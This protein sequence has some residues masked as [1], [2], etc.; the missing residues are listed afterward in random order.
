MA[1]PSLFLRQRNTAIVVRFQEEE[2]DRLDHVGEWSDDSG[3]PED[4]LED[5]VSDLASVKTHIEADSSDLPKPSDACA[6]G[7][8]GS[9]SSE[10]QTTHAAKSSTQAARLHQGDVMHFVFLVDGSLSMKNQDVH[11]AI[12]EGALMQRSSKARSSKAGS[13]KAR[14]TTT[15]VRRIDAV[16]KACQDFLASQQ[17]VPH[18]AKDLFSLIS[19]NRKA[20]VHFDRLGKDEADAFLEHAGASAKPCRETNYQ[21]AF[22]VV[23]RLMGLEAAHE[24][25]RIILLSDG[26]INSWNKDSLVDLFEKELLSTVRI[27]GARSFEVHAVAFGPDCEAWENLRPLAEITGGTLHEAALNL[28]DLRVA[29]T[30][31]SMTISS[32]R[33]TDMQE[34]DKAQVRQA[35]ALQIPFDPLFGNTV[36]TLVCKRMRHHY[37]R[38][39][40]RFNDRVKMSSQRVSVA[41]DPKPFDYGG[42]RLVYTMK[43][44]SE[45]DTSMVAKR[46]IKRAHADREQMLP[47]CRCTSL[48]IEI[49]KSFLPALKKAS[50]PQRQIWFLICYLYEYEPS[51]GGSAYFVAEQRLDGKFTKFNGNNG[52]VNEGAADTEIM[53][54]F[55]HYSFIKTNGMFMVVDLQGVVDKGQY[56]LTDPQVHSR[57][58]LSYGRGDLGFE[59]IKGFFETHKCGRTCRALDL[60]GKQAALLKSLELQKDRRCQLCVDAPSKTSFKPCGHSVACRTCA[61]RLFETNRPSCPICRQLVTDFEEGLFSKTNT[62]RCQ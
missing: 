34:E 11:C 46:L 60:P 41:V 9:S 14:S 32:D 28:A 40:W 51:H 3:I 37:D 10:L 19:F 1:D 43:D 39:K 8:L 20:A 31:I 2:E 21:A 7:G 22:K 26:Q 15:M 36:C 55:S 54:A 29:F 52:F 49:R 58:R 16:F 53:Q 18:T 50:E 59:G 48:A 24:N 30:S 12:E 17:K 27:Q 5:M 23:Y 38:V 56:L 61:L 44:A 33:V 45:P 62:R 47:F 25:V 6:R 13:S 57:D 4:E 42:M 35:A